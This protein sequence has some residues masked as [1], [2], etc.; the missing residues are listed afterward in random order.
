[1]RVK[2]GFVVA[3]MT[4]AALL[5][6][7]GIAAGVHAATAPAPA[8]SPPAALAAARAATAALP[9]SPELLAEL[10]GSAPAGA[11][12]AKGGAVPGI[13]VAAF[14]HL[15]GKRIN[16]AQVAAA[17][18]RFAAVKVTEGDYYVNPWAATDLSAAKAAGLYVTAYHFAI[19]NVSGGAA[20]ARYALRYAGDA[21]GGNTLPPLLDIEY[22]PY[23]STDGTNMCYGLG[24]SQM[25]SW[26]AA[27]VSTVRKL[28]GQYPIIYTT[29]DWWDTCTGAST[30]FGADPMWVAA[31][32]FTRPPLPS[33]W[34]TWT[35]WQYTSSGTVPGV[36]S[37]GETDLS[38]F[39]PGVVGLVD[40]GN[41]RSRATAAVRLHVN[42]LDA[43]AWKPL[44]Y[45]ATGL[46]PGL[47]MSRSGTIAGRVGRTAGMY[48]VTVQAKNP[49]GSVGSVRFSWQVRG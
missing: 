29:A 27:F 25:T 33:G 36:D 3:A 9:H 40:P 19:P 31:Y 8:S 44:S 5:A 4:A 6:V 13:D 10:A 42:A 37:P 47:T 7:G 43:L 12:A 38:Y 49:A 23:V 22:D 2:P 32:G 39:D 1:V 20:Q 41:R 28:S 21:T 45:Q 34:A 18:Y 17:G 26:I 35:F 30:A 14:Q 48:H 46:P 24:W 11:G 16:W 15:D